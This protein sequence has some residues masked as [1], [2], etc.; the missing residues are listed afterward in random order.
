MDVRHRLRLDALRRIDDHQRALASRQRARHLVGEVDVPRRVEQVQL[1][2]VP[3]LGLVVHGDRVRLDRDAAFALQVHGVEVL[4][5]RLAVRDRPRHSKPVGKRGLPVV[6]VGDDAEIA[7][8]FEVGHRRPGTMG[9][10]PVASTLG[11]SRLTERDARP[12]VTNRYGRQ[13]TGP[14]PRGRIDGQPGR[15]RKSSHE[16]PPRLSVRVSET[17]SPPALARRAIPCARSIRGC[18]VAAR[19]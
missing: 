2:D 7:G 19:D 9:G 14:P 18:S 4:V 3:V 10:G 5:L 11:R 6:D 16:P 17:G 13:P 15:T 1:V 8:K 12:Q